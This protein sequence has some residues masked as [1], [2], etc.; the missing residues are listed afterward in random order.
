MRSSTRSR[1]FTR[2]FASFILVLS[3]ALIACSSGG[4]TAQ[5]AKPAA[6]PAQPAQPAAQPSAAQP[7]QPAAQP[8]QPA[9]S[10]QSSGAQPAKP[11]TLNEEPDPA[12]VE[13]AK[14]EGKISW[15]CAI[16]LSLAKKLA[17]A[18][19][20]KYG[21]PVE[22]NRNGSERIFA[23][24]MKEQQTKVYTNDVVNTSDASNF[25]TMKKEGLLAPYK[26]KQIEVFNS[27]LKSH[28]VGPEDYYNTLGMSANVIVYNPEKVKE[29]D[30]PKAWKEVIDPKWKG[31]LVHAHPSYSGNVLTSM[32]LL[33]GIYGDEYYKALA[34]NDPLIVQSALDVPAKTISGER[35]VG[36]GSSIGGALQ[37][38]RKN[39][40]LRII[41]PAD[42]MPLIQQPIA[43]AKNSQ[44][45]NAAKL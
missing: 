2:A 23:Q 29:A 11:G 34:K 19:Q 40:P 31:K 42:G 30:A 33:R 10:G 14:K 1:G 27:Q 4:S 38:F 13:A 17:E 37:A 24:F 39:Q 22:V 7:A 32:S 41:F 44:K 20:K 12:L 3:L 35:E 43:L 25:V 6:Q 5:P 21:I 45:P 8:A 18:F 9:A 15:Y 36:S 16:E 28:L 26:I